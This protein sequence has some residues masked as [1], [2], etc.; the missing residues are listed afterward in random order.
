MD[1]RDENCEMPSNK[2]KPPVVNL[3][4]LLSGFRLALVPALVWLAWN[5]W[6]QFFLAC[7]I[8]SLATDFL[9]GFLA[10]TLN[11]ASERGAEL[12]SWADFATTLATPL[13]AWWLWPELIRRE[14]CFVI[15]G[16]GSYSAAVL[17]GLAKYRRLT[18]YHTW[19]SKTTAVLMGLGVPILLLGGP[20]WPFEWATA[21]L[22]TAELEEIVITALLPEWRANVP[23]F[24]HAWKLDREAKST[25]LK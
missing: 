22:V 6:S 12:D 23:S 1:P 21:V 13:C 14:S 24:R 9:D 8:A 2:A 19:A 3:P 4:N 11:Q 20:A 25:Q 5:G 7:F 15:A 16:L 18:S 10:R 17:F